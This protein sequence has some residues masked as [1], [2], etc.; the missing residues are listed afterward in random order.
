MLADFCRS[1]KKKHD[2]CFESVLF[3]S[4]FDCFC[5]ISKKAWTINYLITSLALYFHLTGFMLSLLRVQ[6]FRPHW[7]SEAAQ[8]QKLWLSLEYYICN[9]IY[10]LYHIKDQRFL[11]SKVSNKLQRLNVSLQFLMTHFWEMTMM[12]K[13]TSLQVESRIS[14]IMTGMLNFR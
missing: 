2:P 8:T 4:F 12:E 14:I 3:L 11:K 10:N 6:G 5:M 7:W 13:R 1:S 9:S